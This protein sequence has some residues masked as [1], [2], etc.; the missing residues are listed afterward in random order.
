M[1]LAASVLTL[2]WALYTPAL[3]LSVRPRAGITFPHQMSETSSPVSDGWALE[4][5][6]SG[7]VRLAAKDNTFTAVDLETR[8]P[9]ST[10]SPGIGIGLEE[11]GSDGQIGLVLVG[12]IVEDGNAAS[13]S[14]ALLPG[15]ALISVSS[16]GMN[17]VT[18]EGLTYDATIEALTSID[19]AAGD[20]TFSVRRLQRVPRV[21]VTLTFPPEDNRPDESLTLIPGQP[22]RNT[23]LAKGIK[24]NDPLARRFDA[25]CASLLALVEIEPWRSCPPPICAIHAHVA[26]CHDTSV[27]SCDVRR[28]HW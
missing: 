23:M 27:P 13:A 15:D 28:W 21:S 12:F 2:S 17:P 14:K 4:R 7:G 11:F 3:P 18:L 9:R 16:A 26:S 5:L 19:P 10:E 6:K 25:G 20:L 22:L 24:L 8:V 1:M